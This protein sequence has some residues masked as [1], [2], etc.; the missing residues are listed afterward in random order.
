ME[1]N[2]KSEKY[3]RNPRINAEGRAQCKEVALD[4]DNRILSI[5]NLEV[6]S[7]G[8]K[9]AIETVELVF[10]DALPNKPSSRIILIPALQSSRGI[11]Q[12]FT[13]KDIDNRY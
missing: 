1:E 11:V 3:G 2:P 12:N 8:L 7:S 9:R 5:F 6:R 13:R 10:K 4:L